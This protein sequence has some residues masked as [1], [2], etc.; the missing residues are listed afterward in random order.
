[1]T[2]SNLGLRKAVFTSMLCISR[3]MA[4]P[5]LTTHRIVLN[6][7]TGANVSLKSTPSTWVNPLATSLALYLTTCP[8]A[9]LL[10]EKT[11]LQ[12][13]LDLLGGRGASSQ[14]PL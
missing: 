6:L 14:V 3:S 11:H 13:T 1:M 5:M 10:V 12:P 4:A 2:S 7:A 9:S 8:K